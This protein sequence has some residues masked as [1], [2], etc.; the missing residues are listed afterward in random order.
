M[1][2]PIL[3][4]LEPSLCSQ[5]VRLALAEKGVAYA[6]RTVDIGPR[7][8]NYEPWYA[9]INPDLV[10]PTLVHD[11]TPVVDSAQIVRYVDRAFD[12]P[13]LAPADPSARERMEYLVD[14]A[15]ALAI[16]ELSYA[17][18][19]GLLAWLPR[20]TMVRR[21]WVLRRNLRRNPDLAGVYRRKLA[22]VDAWGE[23]LATPRAIEAIRRDVA[24]ALAEVDHTLSDGRSFLCGGGWSLA[25]L[26]WTVVVARLRML[27]WS[28]QLAAL[29]HLVAWYERMRARPSFRQAVLVERFDPS[30]IAP[31]VLPWLLPRVAVVLLIGGLVVGGL[32]AALR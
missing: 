29:P 21:R 23:S 10:V 32:V 16:R 15:D 25:D 2:E 5:K 12:G 19:P 4:N 9:R 20:L 3:Y 26:M 18:P 28:E 1:P 6:S 8:E 22:D 27:G 31:L 13:Q 24:D 7:L 17:R 11:G 14:R 30:Y